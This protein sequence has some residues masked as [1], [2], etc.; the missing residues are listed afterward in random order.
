MKTRAWTLAALLVLTAVAAHGEI[1][2]VAVGGDAAPDGNGIFFDFGIPAMNRSGQ[3]TFV[4]MLNGT[5][6][7]NTDNTGIFRG[8]SIPGS[9]AVIVRRGDPSP[10]S[11]GNFN[12]LDDDSQPVINDAGQVAFVAGLSGTFGGGSDNT[13]IFRSGGTAAGLTVIVRQGE[14]APGG[15]TFANF[16]GGAI[17]TFSLNEMGQVAFLNVG[18]GI[19]QTSGDPAT[20]MV[21]FLQPL[22]DGDGIFS[23]LSVP[24][25]ND[26]GQVAFADGLNG[27]FRGDGSTI[28]QIARP[29][30]AAPDGNGTF[31]APFSTPAM[32]N[33]GDV[34]FFA[35]LTGTSGGTSDNQGIFIRKG[36]ALTTIVRRGQAAPNGNG[37]F[38]DLSAID[39]VA[40]NEAGQAAFVATLTATSGGASDNTGLFRGDG[41]T[42][43]QIVRTGDLAPD[44]SRINSIGKPAL[45]DA[46]QVAFLGG[47]VAT[48]GVSTPHAI[49]LYDDRLGLLQAVRTG[50]PLLGSTIAI[51][52]TLVFEPSTTFNGKKR[53]GLNEEGQVVFRFDLSDGRRGIAVADPLAPTHTPTPTPTATDTPPPSITPTP[54]PT[55]G[56]VGCVGDC[57]D[58]GQVTV[59][60][61]SHDGE[62]RPRQAAAFRPAPLAMRTPMGKSPST[63]SSRL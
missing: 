36:D 27:I 5:T 43:T 30:V 12:L 57:N 48:G 25:L 9:L 62:H 56:T 21:R 20:Q 19:F 18:L 53:S 39:D 55:R 23:S 58:D 44:G 50:D 40:V 45:N 28:L 63:R 37:R 51:D 17:S 46:G 24:S 31:S 7:G 11:N 8:T 33:L 41:T 35:A 54:R 26:A 47:L 14:A 49:F 34:A 61:T 22:P 52:S 1:D 42:L 13:G 59:D 16:R 3:V 15:G 2:V 38:L 6:G 29:G 4:S 10:D 32:N 60:E